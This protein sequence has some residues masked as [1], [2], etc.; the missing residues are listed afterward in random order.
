MLLKE[1]SEAR[2]VSGD[3]G[4]VR[5]IIIKAIRNHVSELHIDS[6]GSITAIRKGTDSDRPRV[7]VAAHMDEIGFMVTGIE[8]NGLIR[9]TS[10]GGVDDRILPGLRV[11]I[12]DKAVPGV[13]LWAPI[14]KNRDQSIVKLDSLRIDIGASDKGGVNAS[15]KPGDRIA[16]DAKFMEIG[17]DMLRGKAFDDRV[18]CAMLVDLLQNGPYACDLLAAFTVQE[19]VGLR[20]AGVAASR[21]QP[22]AAIVLEGTT[23]HDL[24]DPSADA[25]EDVPPNPGTRLGAGPALTVMDNSMIVHRGLLD[26]LK[27]QAET[28]S[29]PFQY[30]MIRGGGT[31]GGA[32]HLTADGIPTAVISTPCRYIHSPSA[33]LSRRDYDN[34]LRLAQAVLNGMTH[35]VLKA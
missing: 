3:E 15:V 5:E 13:I 20:G 14:H 18:G 22:D 25:D 33:Y 6:M 34:G 17:A 27:Q 32:I 4:A 29:I 16:F 23:A 35:D 30:K 7:M 28:E 26:L 8:S 2:G 21:L 24:P 31:D 10:I 1:L 12:G 9:F 11:V 19:E